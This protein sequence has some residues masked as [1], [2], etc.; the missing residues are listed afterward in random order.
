MPNAAGL[1]T[2]GLNAS[3]TNRAAEQVA[4]P[5]AEASIRL[6]AFDR[7]G[8]EVLDPVSI[9]IEFMTMADLVGITPIPKGTATSTA[10]VAGTLSNFSAKSLGNASTQVNTLAVANLIRINNQNLTN[11]V[12][13]GSSTATASLAG[14][15]YLS[16]SA[17]VTSV[18]YGNLLVD[19]KLGGTAQIRLDEDGQLTKIHRLGG[20]AGITV[21]P[22]GALS[23]VRRLKTSEQV[24]LSVAGNLAQL[25]KRNIGDVEAEILLT[26]DGR[27]RQEHYLGGETDFLFDTT[28][29]APKNAAVRFDPLTESIQFDVFGRVG[30]IQFFQGES[31]IEFDVD[32]NLQNNAFEPDLPNT[33]MYRVAVDTLMVKV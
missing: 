8:N 1:N 12:A 28:A 26:V 17:S 13:S 29:A 10:V 3:S 32:G 4:L 18:T 16:G 27:L 9:G 30:A 24:T 5:L 7:E 22:R 21:T 19:V 6:L 25:R 14:I 33:T 11:V 31:D 20:S 2:S 23:S 15:R